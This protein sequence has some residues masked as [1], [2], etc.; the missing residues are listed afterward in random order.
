[1]AGVISIVVEP[2]SRGADA[3]GAK[4][5]LPEQGCATQVC[6]EGKMG[7]TREEIMGFRLPPVEATCGITKP[8]GNWT[9]LAPATGELV[10]RAL[11]EADKATA[12][13]IV[14]VMPAWFEA[15]VIGVG[16][17]GAGTM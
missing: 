4:A 7:L 5:E 11:V 9:D 15:I 6:E 8:I 10:A 3:A 16:L 13:L 17:G 1:L 14:L 12:C 2:V